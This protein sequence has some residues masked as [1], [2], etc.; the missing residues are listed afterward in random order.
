MS[1]AVVVFK[2]TSGRLPFTIDDIRRIPIPKPGSTARIKVGT[3]GAVVYGGEC[4]IVRENDIVG[5]ATLL[6]T[7][8]ALVYV[9]KQVH[10]CEYHH[11]V[12]ILWQEE[13]ED[14]WETVHG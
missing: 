9:A 8:F 1:N 12:D 13:E 3:I 14:G 6:A 5:F 7:H 4:N 10:N 2:G 11:N